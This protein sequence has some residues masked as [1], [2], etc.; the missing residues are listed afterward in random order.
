ACRANN[1]RVSLSRT[2]SDMPTE[3][4]SISRSCVWRAAARLTRS[5]HPTR[6]TDLCI[7]IAPSG[8][9]CGKQAIARLAQDDDHAGQPFCRGHAEAIISEVRHLYLNSRKLRDEIRAEIEAEL[10]QRQE[11]VKAR[12][13]AQ[14]EKLDR[15]YFARQGD[16]VKIG[17]SIQPDRRLRG[18]ETQGGVAFIEVVLVYG[19]RA[20]EQRYHRRFANSRLDGE[21][22]TVTS[23]IRAEMDHIIE[24]GAPSI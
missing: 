18:L 5:G 12:R 24:R 6:I 4:C 23:A 20:L 19:G 14:A 1:T 2:G 9:P 11:V 21:W 16:R 7:G 8:E 22:F 10:E 13:L 17:H 15:V 3:P